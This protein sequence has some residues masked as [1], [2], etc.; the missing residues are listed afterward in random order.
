MLKLNKRIKELERQ[1]RVIKLKEEERRIKEKTREIV[2][3][4]VEY[5]LC[6]RKDTAR[7]IPVIELIIRME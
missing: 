6:K 3:T 2:D 5:E 4:F 7:V 1:A